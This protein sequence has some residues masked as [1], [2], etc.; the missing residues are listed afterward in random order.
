MKE[1]E[2]EA[3]AFVVSKAIGLNPSTSASDYIQLYAGDKD[4]LMESLDHIQ[5][6]ASFILAALDGSERE[7]EVADAA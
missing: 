4:V 7:E 2:A 6:T 1:T 3:V 5:K